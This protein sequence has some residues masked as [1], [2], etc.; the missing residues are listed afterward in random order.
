MTAIMDEKKKR[1][2]EKINVV[3]VESDVKKQD[4]WSEAISLVLRLKLAL[5]GR[6]CGDERW[7]SIQF[8]S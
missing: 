6:G 1:E 4:I 5:L 3:C 2:K 8:G 7:L